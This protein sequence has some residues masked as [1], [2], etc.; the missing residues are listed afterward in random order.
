M[1]LKTKAFTLVEL[2]VVITVLAILATIWFFSLFGYQITARDAVRVSDVQ[3]LTKIV[4]LYRLEKG[5]FPEVSNPVEVSFSGSVIWKQWHFWEDTRSYARR[6]SEVPIDPLTFSNY[7]Y[8]TTQ[9]TGEYQIGAIVEKR[10]TLWS[11]LLPNAHAVDTWNLLKVFASTLVKWNYNGQFIAHKE[12]ERIYILAAP[13]I[14]ADTISSVTLQEVHTANAFVYEWGLNAPATYSWTLLDESNWNFNPTNVSWDETII[15]EWTL[16]DLNSGGGKIQLVSNIKDYYAGTDVA[17]SE[18]Y[19]RLINLDPASNPDDAIAVANWYIYGEVW[20]L[21]NADVRVTEIS[22]ESSNV[23]SLANNKTSIGDYS[24]AHNEFWGFYNASVFPN[25][26]AFAALKEDGSITAWWNATYGWTGAPTGTGFVKIYS[27]YW[28]FAAL[29]ADGSIES[30]WWS[31]WGGIW[32]PTGSGFTS[33][34][35]SQRALAALKNGAIT[36]WWHPNYGWAWAPTGTGFTKIFSNRRALV[37]LRDDGTLDAW[38]Y[39]SYGWTGE[40]TGGNFIHIHAADRAF[41]WLKTDGSIE[42]WGNS[43]YGGA[44]EPS[45]SGFVKISSTSRAFAWLKTDGSIEAWWSGSYGGTWTPSWTWFTNISATERAFAW[46]KPDG[47]IEVWWNS[48][49]GWTWEPTG[50]GFTKV[51]ANIYAFT[52]LKNDGSISAWWNNSYGWTWEPTGTG[53]VQVYSTDRAFAV[54]HEDGTV[55]SWWDSSYGGTGAPNDTDILQVYSNERAFAALKS[56]GSI[57]AWWSATQGWMW[58]P[59][60]DG[61]VG[62]NGGTNFD[63]ILSCSLPWGWTNIAHG[64]DVTAYQSATVQSWQTCQSQTRTCNDGSLSGAYTYETCVVVDSPTSP[65]LTHTSNTSIVE[66]SFTAGSGLSNCVIQNYDGSSW[67]TMWS[68]DCNSNA[69]DESFSLGTVGTS[70]NGRQVRLAADNGATPLFTFSTTLSCVATGYSTSSTPTIDEDCDGN[71]NNTTS[72][73]TIPWCQAGYECH[74]YYVYENSGCTGSS[75][76]ST[77]MRSCNNPSIAH[78]CTSPTSKFYRV[79]GTGCTHSQTRYW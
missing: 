13:S 45:G 35:S 2:I 37:W 15:Y 19:A 51:F 20:G 22:Q 66:I 74:R 63:P 44:G 28:V 10:E 17:K 48:S 69:V 3:N 12:G 54:L 27:N 70:W 42:A 75:T 26:Y 59:T 41:A 68:I 4:E 16:D 55:V 73:G 57:Q 78:G 31:S 49:Y 25:G 23:S 1:L 30:W 39:S 67:H 47:S 58:E 7:A 11:V 40:P 21:W 32:E 34:A 24:A 76:F 79:G 29:K 52:A 53:F 38:G 8:S 61:H 46:L 18:W 33:I 62:L 56:D 9:S 64:T 36:A 5:V 6:I 14:L 72:G 77:S 50:T 71:Y 43:S 65:T 60:D